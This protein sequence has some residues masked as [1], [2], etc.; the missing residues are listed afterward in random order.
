MDEK[1]TRLE[2]AGSISNSILK[3]LRAQTLVRVLGIPFQKLFDKPG[4]THEFLTEQAIRILEADGFSV[5]ASF[6]EGWLDT[7]ISGSYWADARWMN[8]THHYNP[9]TRRGLWIWPG[10]ADQLRNWYNLAASLWRR[11]R[12]ERS[13]LILGACLHVVQD[14]CQPYHANCMVFDGHQ[15]YER[16]ADAHKED[17]AVNDGGLYGVSSRPEGWA[18]A[19]AELACGYLGPV[20]SEAEGE[21]ERS[22]SVLLPR[23]MRTTAGFLLFFREEA[24]EATVVACA[25]KAAG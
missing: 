6:Y 21:R 24:M 13:M 17:Y 1:P 22:T 10:A 12:H 14:C 11:G 3:R 18:V 2:K 4:K 9:K 7:L 16:W 25:K 19:N 5:A 8:A 15:E 23:A 20:S